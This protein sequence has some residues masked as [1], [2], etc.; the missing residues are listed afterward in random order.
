MRKPRVRWRR[1]SDGWD[2]S[3][4]GRTFYVSDV[5][6]ST[7]AGLA[8]INMRT[9]ERCVFSWFGFQQTPIFVEPNKIS[10]RSC[11]WMN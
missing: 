3:A 7:A 10:K 9:R 4:N 1:V 8:P 2:V 6:T 5:L 11:D